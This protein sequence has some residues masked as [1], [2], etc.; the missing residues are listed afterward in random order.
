MP[1]RAVPAASTKSATS[2]ASPATTASL[3]EPSAV[4]VTADQCWAQMVIKPRSTQV[5]QNFVVQEG[6]DSISIVPEELRTG[7]Q[8]VSVKERSASFKLEE[9]KFTRVTESIKVKDEVKRLVVEP[10]R[11]KEEKEEVLV[12][13]ERI[14]MRS[15]RSAGVKIAGR[16]DEHSQQ[17]LCAVKVPAV[18][19]TETRQVLVQ[20]ETV[21]E[22]IT[23]AVYKTISK[24]VL[25]EP[26]K[27]IPV[28]TP[29]QSIDIPVVTV[30]SQARSVVT[31]VAPKTKDLPLTT[32]D[33]PPQLTWRRVVCQHES[34]PTMV[35]KL[36]E[37]L[38]REGFAV[39]KV[40]GKLGKKTLSAVEEYQTQKGIAAGLL[41][42][43]ALQSLGIYDY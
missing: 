20:P 8:T 39:G 37:A 2:I 27:A 7:V 9:P 33:T 22:E 43:E 4:S 6:R 11:Y 18:Y 36:Q 38:T 19:R 34:T 24:M 26:G 21:R 42:Y 31:E 23:P 17:S 35:Q 13:S 3:A 14:E 15:C 41:T 5:M 40:D 12:E 16:K 1:A 25:V 29:P 28:E 32:Y 10:A 30:A